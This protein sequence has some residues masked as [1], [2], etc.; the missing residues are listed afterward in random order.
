M[1]ELQYLPSCSCLM[2]LLWRTSLHPHHLPRRRPRQ[3]PSDHHCRRV[4]LPHLR[5]SSRHSSHR[6]QRQAHHHWARR[7]RRVQLH[8][9][10]SL[11]PAPPRPQAAPQPRRRPQPQLRCLQQRPPQRPPPL[12]RPQRRQLLRR[13]QRRASPY[14]PWSGSRSAE[15]GAQAAR[16]GMTVLWVLQEPSLH[17]IVGARQLLQLL[18][19]YRIGGVRL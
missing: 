12:R 16:C 11:L 8:P 5:R 17:P 3:S 10:P 19:P 15:V 1:T 7:R 18:P 2:L 6:A 13:T 9:Q 4:R 14:R